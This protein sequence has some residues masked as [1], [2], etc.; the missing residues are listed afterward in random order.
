MKHDD[1]IY[2]FHKENA[3]LMKFNVK[4]LIKFNIK[5]PVLFNLYIPSCKSD[6]MVCK[7]RF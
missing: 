3:I 4:L 1:K 6:E 7:P 2:P 5:A